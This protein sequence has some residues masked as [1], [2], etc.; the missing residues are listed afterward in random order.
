MIRYECNVITEE[1]NK[2][3]MSESQR[4]SRLVANLLTWA[5]TALASITA[6]VLSYEEVL[7]Q[8]DLQ[9]GIGSF[10]KAL[11]D[12]IAQGE[13]SDVRPLGGLKTGFGRI[14]LDESTFVIRKWK[15]QKDVIE[16]GTSLG[17]ERENLEKSANALL[18]YKNQ[19]IA[20]GK[21]YT[22]IL[23]FNKQAEQKRLAEK[24]KLTRRQEILARVRE[25]Y[26]EYNGV[27]DDK[28]ASG[29]AKKYPSFKP[30]LEEAQKSEQRVIIQREDIN[31]QLDAENDSRLDK[32]FDPDAFLADEPQKQQDWVDLPD[33]HSKESAEYAKN[34]AI[35]WEIQSTTIFYLKIAAWTVGVGLA[36]HLAA[37]F[38]LY[39]IALLWWFIIDRLKDLSG[40]VKGK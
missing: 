1:Q 9:E 17:S 40:A 29:L 32:I 25:N 37:R 20:K 31:T 19:S 35:P 16:R 8:G 28:L 36:S 11:A 3:P 14:E 23:L 2:P 22:S 26:P 13:R 10:E 21:I 4:R 12:Y 15:T 39:V 7:R 33:E 34:S 27:S 38:S 6:A 18:S 30:F 5:F 24:S